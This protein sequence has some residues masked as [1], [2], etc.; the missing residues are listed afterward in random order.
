M[1]L[2][3]KRLVE[4]PRKSETW[5]EQPLCVPA[6]VRFSKQQNTS[7]ISLL[8]EKSMGLDKTRFLALLL[9]SLSLDQSREKVEN[10]AYKYEIFLHPRKKINKLK[11]KKKKSLIDMEMWRWGWKGI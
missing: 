3:K 2:K 4:I 11:M 6:C 5:P 7:R 1:L 9:L 10:Y 8:W